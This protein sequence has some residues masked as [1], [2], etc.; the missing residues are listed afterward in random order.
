M[1]PG[2]EVREGAFC[3]LL[4]RSSCLY[5]SQLIMNCKYRI[6]KPG[7]S[8]IVLS[9]VLTQRLLIPNWVLL[10][11][12]SFIHYKNSLISPGPIQLRNGALGG[13]IN[14]GA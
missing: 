7:F 3:N 11:A 12:L 2:G 10:G 8:S 4:H 9:R 13:L 14:G 6:S 1:Y 5:I